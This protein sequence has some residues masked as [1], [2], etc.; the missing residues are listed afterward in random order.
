MTDGSGAETRRQQSDLGLA[1][2][3][4]HCREETYAKYD[5]A[6]GGNPLESFAVPKVDLDKTSIAGFDRKDLPV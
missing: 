2:Q 3:K 1:A 6:K 4:V 5:P